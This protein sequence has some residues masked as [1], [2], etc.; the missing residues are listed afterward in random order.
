MQRA[1]DA[2]AHVAGIAPRLDVD[3]AGALLKR[4][5]KQPVADMNDVRVVGIQL[6]AAPQLHQLLEIGDVA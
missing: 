1:V 6:A 2:K 4:I 5:G 3:I